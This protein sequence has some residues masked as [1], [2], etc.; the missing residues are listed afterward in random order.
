[1]ST[2]ATRPK[3]DSVPVNSTD[4]EPA[5]AAQVMLADAAE[6][7]EGTVLNRRNAHL[8]ISAGLGWPGLFAEAGRDL[9]ETWALRRLIWTLAFLDIKLRYRGSLIGPFWLTLSTGVMIAALGFVYSHLFHTDLHTYL[10]FLSL[11][12]VLWNNFITSTVSD[13]C[14]SYTSASATIHSMRMPMAM[15]AARTV[16][17]NVMVLAHSVI[18]IVIVF[19]LMHTWPGRAAFL[20][21]PA[22]GLWLIDGLAVSMLLGGFCARFRD[23]PPIV[24]SIMQIAFFVSPIIWSPAIL[25]DRGIGVI[26]LNWN[27]FYALLQ[28]MRAPLLNQVPSHATWIAALG[29]SAALVAISGLFFVRAR[30]RVAFWV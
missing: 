19:A 2:T 18:V 14:L 12:L 28:I 1:M 15:H 24:A 17:R 5:D 29:Y 25:K 10:P 11:S 16:V 30:S 8:V 6:P 27:P 9:R 21:I 7:G 26:L 3:S 13:A 22:F 4:S 23:V 20:A